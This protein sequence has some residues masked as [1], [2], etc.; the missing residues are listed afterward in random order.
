[1]TSRVATIALLA[2]LTAAPAWAQNQQNETPAPGAAGEMPHQLNQQDRDFLRQAALGSAAEVEMGRLAMN[3]AA[4]P[5]VREFGRWMVTDHTAIDEA[6][7]RLSRRMGVTPAS[8]IDPQDQAM[9]DKLRGLHGRAFD[10]QYIPAQIEGH[11]QTIAL[12]E[13]QE[14]EGQDPVLKSLA[15]HTQPM[16]QQHLAAVQELAQLPEV[17]GRRGHVGAGSTVPP[18]SPEN[19]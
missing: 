12:F 6:L 11:Q 17:A 13:R 10:E 1:M 8:G 5:A 4:G 14:S 19:R 9:I 16:L 18:R 3:Q 15:R 7:D 2:L